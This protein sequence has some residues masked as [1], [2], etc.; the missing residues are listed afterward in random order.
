MDCHPFQ[1]RRRHLDILLSKTG[2]QTLYY[3]AAIGPVGRDGTLYT[4][5]HFLPLSRR[6]DLL[7]LD[8]LNLALWWYYDPGKSVPSYTYPSFPRFGCY[9]G[10]ELNSQA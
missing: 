1:I 8:G 10:L 5:D 3:C 6:T 9:G 7:R 2:E 4:L